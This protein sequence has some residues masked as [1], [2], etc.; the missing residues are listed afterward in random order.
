MAPNAAALRRLH[1][2]LCHF[3][4][5]EGRICYE[6]VQQV[7]S[8]TS[9][10]ALT[11]AGHEMFCRYTSDHTGTTKEKKSE[12]FKKQQK[13]NQYFSFKKVKLIL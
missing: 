5:H 12:Y 1:G 13:Y 8:A 9:H 11:P 10:A 6:N 7:Y 4:P 2:E 3:S